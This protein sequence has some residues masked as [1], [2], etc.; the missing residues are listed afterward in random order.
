MHCNAGRISC[1]S[2]PGKELLIKLNGLNYCAPNAALVTPAACACY[3]AMQQL[4]TQLPVRGVG[5]LQDSQGQSRHSDG[6][7]IARSYL[8]TLHSAQH[9][10]TGVADG[11]ALP[12]HT[13]CV[14]TAVVPDQ[15]SPDGQAQQ[16]SHRQGSPE[17]AAEC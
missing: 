10:S 8:G 6:A 9:S 5:G 11:H 7:G 16:A 1:N 15:V 4:S 12:N 13:T 3:K 2:G 17:S 14:R